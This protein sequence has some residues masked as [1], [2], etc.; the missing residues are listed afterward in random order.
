MWLSQA[1]EDGGR[2]CHPFQPPTRWPEAAYSCVSM[3]D[4]AAITPWETPVED[5]RLRRCQRIRKGSDFATLG[6]SGHRCKFCGFAFI[7]KQN[8]DDNALPRIGIVTSRKVG[9]AVRR[10]FLKR[11]TRESFR[12]FPKELLRG[13]DFLIIF[14]SDSKTSAVSDLRANLSAAFEKWEYQR[15]SLDGMRHATLGRELPLRSF[16]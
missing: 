6:R 13:Y 1:H 15:K 5:F 8:T 4:V 11:I 9:N 7:W 14:R 2:S 16:E 3:A 10:N 12:H